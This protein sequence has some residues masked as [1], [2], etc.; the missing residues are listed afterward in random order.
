MC[1]LQLTAVDALNASSGDK[2]VLAMVTQR[3]EGCF[4]LE[5]LSGSIPLDLASVV[6]TQRNPL[7]Y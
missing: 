7:M 1:L 6:R 5:D 4:F 2:Y 3:E